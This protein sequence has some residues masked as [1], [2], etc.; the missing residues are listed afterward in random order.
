MLPCT[1]SFQVYAS[2]QAVSK[3]LLVDVDSCNGIQWAL[4]NYFLLVYLKAN[5]LI[6]DEKTRRIPFQQVQIASS[7]STF[8][9]SNDYIANS[10]PCTKVGTFVTGSRCAKISTVL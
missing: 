7:M 6:E 1:L 5:V 2:A 10:F 8:Y 3:N 4:E 9:V